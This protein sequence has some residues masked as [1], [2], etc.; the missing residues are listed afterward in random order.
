VD[1]DVDRVRLVDQGDVH[2]GE[3]KRLKTIKSVHCDT[4]HD[5]AEENGGKWSFLLQLMLLCAKN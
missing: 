2:A 5:F 1:L 4:C 3:H